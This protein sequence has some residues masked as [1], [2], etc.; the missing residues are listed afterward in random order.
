MAWRWEKE[1]SGDYAIV[2]DGF[3]DGIAQDPLKGMT[4]MNQ[5][6]IEVPGEV[7]VGFPLFAS[8]VSGATMAAPIA[9]SVR[10]Q[11]Y[12][13]QTPVGSIQSWAILD[14]SGQVFEAT[15]YTGTWT[16][17][18]SG[19][20]LTG[21]GSTDGLA[22][23]LGY[24]FK[25]R[26]ANIDYWNGTTWSNAW[27][28]TLT[29]GVKH[30]MYVGTDNVLY[31]TNG[32]FIASIALAD[33]SDPTTFDPTNAA[34]Y[35]VTV[36]KLQLPA[37]DEAISL[38]EIG[39][40]NT[41][42]STLL[43]GGIQNA[44]YPWDKTSANFALPI[45]VAEPYIK[46]IVAVNQNAFIFPG[47][48]Q[49]RGRIYITNGSQADEWFKMPDYVFG[50][51]EPYFEWGDA[52]FH[53]NNLIFGFFVESNANNTILS[54]DEIYAIELETK[55]LRA[56][57]TIGPASGK[58]SATVLLPTGSVSAAGFGYFVGWD[59]DSSA[60]GVGR[61]SGTAG[62]GSAGLT[63]ELIPIGTFLQK[64]TFTQ[65]EYKLRSAL[66]SGENI[67]ITPIVDT[68]GTSALSFL[69]TPGT[70]QIS[71]VA[72]ANFQGVQWLKFDITLI[73]NSA[74]SGVRLRE[75]RIR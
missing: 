19:V 56:I 43:I 57:T 52:M 73:G 34:T 7:S 39:G 60:P 66:E 68:G 25:T 35:T 3:S 30:K 50:I 58:A 51:Q 31:I 36:D 9:G 5:V 67:E 29:G 10:Y 12:T 62:V 48:R 8:T 45:Y 20:S 41:P 72:S 32:N 74:T 61:P 28:T 4:R 40:G 55:K 18:S 54:F 15:S 22:F 11:S 70:G 53:R 59:D 63:T 24:L 38:A 13:A 42:N 23:W 64:K 46:N 26:G 21:A 33:P 49:G 1:E 69:P 14:E 75:I 2:I 65:V 27:V 17:L 6:S 16:Y 37:T 47:N 71:G 44:I